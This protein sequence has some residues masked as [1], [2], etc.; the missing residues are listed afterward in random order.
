M[1]SP[2]YWREIP[3]RYRLEASRCTQCKTVYF[4]PRQI[5]SECKSTGFESYKLPD[6]GRIVTYSVIHV[7]PKEFA[8]TVPYTT[9]I[10]EL[11][12]GVRLTTQIADAEPDDVSI[13]APV[14]LVFRLLYDEG[15]SGIKCYGY[16]CILGE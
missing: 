15:H 8:G 11:T 16:K 4:P 10:V 2:R 6:E 13:G 14:R 9:A 5:C 3:Q 12:D 7:P 1:P